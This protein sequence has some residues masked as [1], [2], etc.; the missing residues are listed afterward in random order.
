MLWIIIS[1][2]NIKKAQ[3]SA[4]NILNSNYYL[5]LCI[6]KLGKICFF[7]HPACKHEFK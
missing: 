6:S 3:V 2:G 5:Y 4:R 7:Y 1:G